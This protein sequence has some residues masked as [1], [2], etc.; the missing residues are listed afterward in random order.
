LAQDSTVPVLQRS[1][2]GH[3]TMTDRLIR[4]L[5]VIALPVLLGA[6]L[7]SCKSMAPS[8]FFQSLDRDNDRALTLGEW[9][10]Y[11][12]THTHAWERCS[13]QDFEVADCDGDLQLSWAEYY[14]YRFAGER[15][16][17]SGFIAKTSKPEFD[18]ATGRFVIRR[19]MRLCELHYAAES[20]AALQAATGAASCSP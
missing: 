10:G 20:V 12:G 17:P 18:A 11:Y 16:I 9:M 6:G 13:G 15:C 5:T 4:A 8:S 3:A 7:P 1:L 2:Y 19:K 14:D